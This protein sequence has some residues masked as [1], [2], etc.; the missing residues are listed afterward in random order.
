[1][2]IAQYAGSSSDIFASQEVMTYLNLMGSES[3]YLFKPVSKS[4][5]LGCY[6]LGF[7]L[8]MIREANLENPQDL[9][10]RGEWTWDKFEEYLKVLTK[11]TNGDGQIDV[12]GMSG[13]WTDTLRNLL[14]SNGAQIAGSDR[15]SVV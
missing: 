7:N 13:W 4:S 15:K 12:Y 14:M 1:M 3:N 6:P 10:D 5:Q 11:D 9:W 8:D 2:D